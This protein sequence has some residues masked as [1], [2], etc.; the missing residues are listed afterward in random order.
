MAESSSLKES[1]KGSATEHIDVRPDQPDDADTLLSKR[2]QVKAMLRIDL[3]VTVVTGVMFCISLMDRT[4]L[5]VA[6]IA[7]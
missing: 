2:E 4:N 3:R 1:A 7:G 6:A 5:G